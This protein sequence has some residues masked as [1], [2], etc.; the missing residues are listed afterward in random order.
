MPHCLHCESPVY[1]KGICH[2]HYQRVRKYGD[3]H[4]GRTH[5]PPEERFWRSVQKGDGCW[6][7]PGREGGR[8]SWFQAGG[9]GS[10]SLLAHRYAY[11][12]TH[13]PIPPGMVVMHSCDVMR[14]VNPAHLSLG[15]HKQNT[16]DM[17]A[18]GRHARKAP[19]GIESPRAKLDEDAV[20]YIRKSD[21]SHAALARRFG[22]GST[23]IRCVRDGR[24][25]THVT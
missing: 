5:A 4:A 8:Y 14:C 11:E 19:V 20:R 22:C 21:E 12:I 18:K 2:K 6:I 17:I 16:A 24:T 1:A 23:T 10:P 15:T 7:K 3:A 25:W 13:G 9:K